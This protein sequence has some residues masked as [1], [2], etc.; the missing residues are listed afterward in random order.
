M[1]IVNPSTT[2]IKAEVIPEVPSV[3]W[4]V[5]VK[6]PKIGP[7][8]I[9]GRLFLQAFKSAPVKKNIDHPKNTG[10]EGTPSFSATKTK[11]PANKP[12]DIEMPKFF[13]IFYTSLI[14]SFN[15]LLFVNF[16]NLSNNL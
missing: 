14:Y 8:I 9:G 5:T 4:A 1:V 12:T 16:M 2:T 7:K 15:S 11:I 6:Y 3:D 13:L 10:H